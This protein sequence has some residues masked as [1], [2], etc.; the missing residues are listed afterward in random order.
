MPSSTS[1]SEPIH[2]GALPAGLRL[3]ASDRPGQAQPV[4]TRDIPDHP[5]PRLALVV[6]VAVALLVAGWEVAMR[7]NGLVAGDIDDSI[8]R[9]TEIRDQ[10]GGK[11][12]VALVSDSRLLFDTDLDRFARMT[13]KKPLQLAVVGSSALVLLKDLA[14]DPRFNGLL[15]VGMADTSYFGQPGFAARYLKTS[16]ET[17]LPSQRTRLWIGEFIEDHLAFVSSDYRLSELLTRIRDDRRGKWIGPYWDVWK[18]STS[19]RR[20]GYVMWDKVETDPHIRGHAIRVWDGFRAEPGEPPFNVPKTLK[21]TAAAVAKIRARGGE[22]VFLRPPSADALRVNEEKRI[23]KSKGWEAILAAAKA[24]GVHAD[25]FGPNRWVLPEQ[26][27]LSRACRTV[28]TDMY[29]RRLVTL[30]DRLRLRADAPP[31]LGIE[32]CLGVGP[33]APA[34]GTA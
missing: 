26:S 33:G 9:W 25:E 23:P 13:G 7:R 22:V 29:I 15:I 11:D 32:D 30:T 6:A 14:D 17:R 2:E 3:T 27:H 28:Y 19:D 16:A 1:P 21:E 10:V 20:R 31:P 4:P 5:W 34:R 18:I 8:A 12:Q 24:K